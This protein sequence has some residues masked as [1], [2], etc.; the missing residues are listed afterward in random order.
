MKSIKRHSFG[1]NLDQGIPLSSEWEFKNLYVDCHG[2][3]VDELLSW[4]KEDDAPLRLGGQI[5][6]GKSSLIVKA[7]KDSGIE[8]DIVFQ[9]D[10]DGLNLSLGD[11]LRIVMVG[12][13]RFA[14]NADMDVSSC[15][16]S[17]ELDDLFGDDWKTGLDQWHS[18]GFLPGVYKKKTALSQRLGGQ[19]DY[20]RN[21]V[22]AMGNALQEKIGRPLFVFASGI[23]KYE[24]DCA[25]YFSLGSLIRMLLSYKTLFEVNAVHLFHTANEWGGIKKRF[26][27][28]MPD[29]RIEKIIAKRMGAHAA[30]VK[31]AAPVLSKMAG[32]NPR[33][34]LRLLS[35]FQ[36]CGK[37]R[38][39]GLSDSMAF[40]VRSTTRDFFSFAPRPDLGIMRYIVEN[41]KIAASEFSLFGDKDTARRAM[42]GNWFFIA[43]DGHDGEWPAQINP[44]VK[45]FFQEDINLKD[46]EVQALEAWARQVDI[47]PA[48]LSFSTHDLSG[49]E[50]K[51]GEKLINDLFSDHLEH[52]LPS[53]LSD[54]FDVMASVLLSKERPDRVLIV[55]KD[56]SVIEAARAYLFGKANSYEYQRFSHTVI[57]GG[58]QATPLR[59]FFEHLQEET[60]I[61]SIEFA[62][63]WTKDQLESLDKARDRLVDRQMIWWIEYDPLMKYFQYWTQLRQLFSV[64]ILDDELLASLS[65]EDMEN[66]L[67]FFQEM[68]DDEQTS[69][70]N[71]FHNLKIVLDYLRAAKGAGNG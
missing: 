13:L 65:M 36:S 24:T 59:D 48:G 50:K 19:A 15:F 52:P 18:D 57:S 10:Q 47:S 58:E 42:Y 31:E 7:F 8:P 70:A 20:Y 17:G 23:D 3:T 35:H 45:G 54:V 61:Y 1:V 6:S 60:D 30:S 69:E 11:F 28:S 38:G 4:L 22:G 66:D 16:L 14:S 5:G 34:A 9:F 44:L 64:F 63:I 39:A 21:V 53:N 32:G 46:P 49:E 71:V 40:A 62:G 25:A 37:K 56:R 68:V 41:G 67:E 26:L 33:Q 43:G 29:E 51:T 55:F 27:P 2:E 12:F